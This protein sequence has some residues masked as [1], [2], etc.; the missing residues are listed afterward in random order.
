[1]GQTPD[2]LHSI[3]T[4]INRIIDSQSLEPGRLTSRR[5]YVHLVY[6]FTLCI[7]THLH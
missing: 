2:H 6:S 3:G 1:M 4:I 5:K 7:L